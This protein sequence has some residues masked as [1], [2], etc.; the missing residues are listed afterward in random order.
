MA[1][2]VE[3]VDE[4]DHVLAVVERG[5]VIRRRWLHLP[6]AQ[7]AFAQYRGLADTGL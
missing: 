3:R 7:E 6:D 1:E 5:G 4:E 2:L